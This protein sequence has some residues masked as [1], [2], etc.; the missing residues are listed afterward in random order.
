MRMTRRELLKV[1]L[2]GGAGAV[3]LAGAPSP[4][5]ADFGRRFLEPLP[6]IQ[7]PAVKELA[8]RAVDAA[9]GAGAVYADVRL[10]HTR[11]RT[12]QNGATTAADIADAEEMTVGVR[13]LVGGYWGFVGSPVWSPDE[14][15]RLGR[16]AVQQAK[17]MAMGPPR[18]VELASVE[19]VRGEH[20][21]T[22][23]EIDPFETSPFEII[24]YLGSLRVYASRARAVDPYRLTADFLVQEKAFASSEGTYCT[25]RLYR[26]SGMFEFR[27]RRR[28]DNLFAEIDVLTPASVGWELFR[29]QP[30]RELIDRVIEELEEDA[31]LPVK[32][33]EVGRYDTVCDARTVAR[34]I[35][36]TLGMATQLDRALG[37]EA[38]ASGTSYLNAP[39]EMVG[40]HEVAAR[41]VTL[42]ADRTQP[43]GAATVAWDD[44]GVRADEWTLIRDGVL[45]DFQTTRESATW[46]RDYYWGRGR[47]VRSHGCAAAPAAVDPPLAHTPNL[48]LAP[49]AEPLDFEAAVAGLKKGLAVKSMQVETDFQGLNG[50]LNPSGFSRVYEVKD[51]KRVARIAG[52]GFLFRAPELWHRVVAL[53]GEQ[54]L[55]R[56]GM[57]ASKG[58]P[59][60]R[61]YHSV[62]APPAVFEAFTLIDPRRKA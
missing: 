39:L 12:Y 19:V 34:L 51:G 1:G 22:P 32:S 47:A 58:E 26:S 20:W 14:M 56:Y 16:E 31:R 49:G 30:M 42:T 57:S 10:T 8:L 52:A 6:P 46:I 15:A 38:N 37:Y 48:K 4:L 35:E 7:D 44:E 27:R 5:L 60:Q 17:V 18:E 53:G 40:N 59:E 11:R 28:D 55:R 29:S 62:T 45:E 36:H 50:S 9:R 2:K 33:V 25:Q 3:L 21:I 61:T 54:S 23:I 24:D 43:G 41:L 13:A